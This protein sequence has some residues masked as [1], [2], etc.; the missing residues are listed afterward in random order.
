[1]HSGGSLVAEEE[2][3]TTTAV[4]MHVLLREVMR[5]VPPTEE[6]SWDDV[7]GE[8]GD[9]MKAI[10]NV[11]KMMKTI[12]TKMTKQTHNNSNVSPIYDRVPGVS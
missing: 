6:N 11:M 12:K 4:G 5:G 8:Q 1:M 9:S 3:V 2:A 10:T 7:V